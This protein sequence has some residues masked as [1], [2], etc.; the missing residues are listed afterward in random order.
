MKMAFSYDNWHWQNGTF[1][2]SLALRVPQ[3]F[4]KQKI[5]RGKDHS[6]KV[7]KPIGQV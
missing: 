5:P 7:L 2:K 3:L 4:T 1:V 6:N